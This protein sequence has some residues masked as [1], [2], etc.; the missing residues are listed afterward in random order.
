MKTKIWRGTGLLSEKTE[1]LYAELND[2]H[3]ERL[4]FTQFSTRMAAWLLLTFFICL[5]DQLSSIRSTS[6]SKEYRCLKNCDS[7]VRP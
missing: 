2:A 4:C 6:R 3:R 1:V 5:H 7:S